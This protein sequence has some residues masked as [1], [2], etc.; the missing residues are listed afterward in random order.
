VVEL[1]RW[2]RGS[3]ASVESRLPTDG[4]LTSCSRQA[5]VFAFAFPGGRR[6]PRHSG[7]IHIFLGRM[8]AECENGVPECEIGKFVGFL[9]SAVKMG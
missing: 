7:L 4:E 5:E 6:Y 8:E 9:V 2:R 1:S 3:C